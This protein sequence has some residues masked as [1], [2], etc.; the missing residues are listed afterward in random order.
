VE[1]ANYYFIRALEMGW[2]ILK[3]RGDATWEKIFPFSVPEAEWKRARDL[4]IQTDIQFRLAYSV[5]ITNES[6]N[7]VATSLDGLQPVEGNPFTID[8]NV[9]KGSWSI[10]EGTV[11][12]YIIS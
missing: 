1:F 8:P 2:E 11:S 4:I 10:D 12:V 9:D 7:V 6:T 5:G 3:T